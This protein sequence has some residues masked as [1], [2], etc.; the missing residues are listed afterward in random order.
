MRPQ[1]AAAKASDACTPCAL[2]T[3]AATQ[4]RSRYEEDM[5]I[6]NHTSVWGS[7]WSDGTWGYACCHQCIKNSYCTGAAGE[8]AAADTAAQMV[9]NM[10]AKAAADEASAAAEHERR[11]ASTLSNA[12]LE[13]GDTW[14][15]GPAEGIDLDDAKLAAALKKQSE[16]DAAKI[17]TDERKRKFNSLGDGND[18]NVSLEEMEAYRL[19]KSRGGDDPLAALKGTGTDGYDLL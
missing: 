2:A 14:G 4:V 17:E 8:A 7:W 12:H 6:G 19:K 16:A 10:E 11:A 3:I 9:A 1:S 18:G 15:G 5:H 13:G